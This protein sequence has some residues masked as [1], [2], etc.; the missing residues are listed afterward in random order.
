MR[1]R[2]YRNTAANTAEVMIAAALA[3]A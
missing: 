2:K 1:C 3:S